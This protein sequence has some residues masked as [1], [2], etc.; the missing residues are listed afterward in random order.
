MQTG[1]SMDL[2]E[3]LLSHDR[4]IDTEILYQGRP[5]LRALTGTF[6]Y[7]AIFLT[8]AGGL[9]FYP[10]EELVPAENISRYSFIAGIVLVVIVALYLL[11]RIVELK[12]ISYMVTTDRIEWERGFLTRKIDNIDMFRVVDLQLH[13]S[14]LEVMLGIGTVKIITTDKTDPEFNFKYVRRP[15]ALYDLLKRA[16]LDSDRRRGV[17]HFE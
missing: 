11:K 1:T 5:S 3:T 6:I 2:Q 13:R 15:R 8:L 4:N 7:A 17:V 9:M 14:L 10:V 16:S 12:L